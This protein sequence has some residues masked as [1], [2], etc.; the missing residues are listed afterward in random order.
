[1]G[2]EEFAK[3]NTKY[4]KLKTAGE[5]E[6]GIPI[7]AMELSDG[8][9]QRKK[10]MLVSCLHGSEQNTISDN[11]S[12]LEAIL[13]S[14]L[15][16]TWDILSIP[17]A[18]PDGKEHGARYNSKGIDLNRDF[19]KREAKE[20]GIIIEAYDKFKPEV[21]LD[22]HSTKKSV[23]SCIIIPDKNIKLNLLKSVISSYSLTRKK[24]SL[25]RVPHLIS[26]QEKI[27]ATLLCE[28]IYQLDEDVGGLVSYAIKESGLAAVIESADN[29]FAAYVSTSILKKLS[30]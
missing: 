3:Q 22:Y 26:T 24:K 30:P 27:F 4:C 28:G 6:Q 29:D 7:Y 10:A 14:D 8:K 23:D 19:I 17:V 5:S 25:T 15:L 2:I 1:M 20:T 13:S 18:N 9:G 21:V 11:L 12:T 16:K